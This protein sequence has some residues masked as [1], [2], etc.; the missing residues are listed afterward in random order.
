VLA[1]SGAV[2]PFL[3]PLALCVCHQH[4]QNPCRRLHTSIQR[5]RNTQVAGLC[6]QLLHLTDGTSRYSVLDAYVPPLI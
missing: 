5:K 2:L 4:A 1:M 6:S 3:V